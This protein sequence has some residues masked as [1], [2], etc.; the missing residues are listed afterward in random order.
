MTSTG[1]NNNGGYLVADKGGI[2]ALSE[3]CA[4][5]LCTYSGHV[6][7]MVIKNCSCSGSRRVKNEEY[8]CR[9]SEEIRL[10]PKEEC[11]TLI[12]K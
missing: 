2:P 7:K 12:C 10:D 1:K 3:V 8:G 6:C 4:P 9:F 5:G 11:N